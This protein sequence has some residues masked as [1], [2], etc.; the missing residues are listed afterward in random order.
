MVVRPQQDRA[1]RTLPRGCTR[2]RTRLSRSTCS[3]Y[4]ARSSTIPAG[5]GHPQ[6]RQAPTSQPD[7][8]SIRRLVPILIDGKQ[9]QNRNNH[10]PPPT[11]HP[12]F[13]ARCEHN[14][15]PGRLRSGITRVRKSC[16]WAQPS[17]P[18]T[19]PK[20]SC[21]PPPECGAK[22]TTTRDAW[23]SFTAP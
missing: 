5:P 16:L 18:T 12:N 22:S 11:P 15:S 1:S 19:T 9:P 20:K 6:S 23:S 17:P 14:K 2:T 3:P 4:I 10:S 8:V 7:R 21:S 13:A